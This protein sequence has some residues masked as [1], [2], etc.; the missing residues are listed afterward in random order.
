M[1]II[2]VSGVPGTGKT[3]LA[4][5]L[6]DYLE[7]PAINLSEYAINSMLVVGYDS[8]IQ[9][10]IV[11]EEK[12]RQ[13]ILELYLSRGPMIIDSHYVEILPRE[14]LEIVFVLRRAPDELIDV[15]LSRGW[16]GRKIA[17]NVEAELLSICT[18]NAVEELGDDLV[19][20]IDVTGRSVDDV[21]REAI[22]I[23]FGSK[24]AYYGHRI[25][26]LSTLS[27]DRIES[28]LRYIEMNR[29]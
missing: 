26:W 19:I 24:S 28:V 6:S 8:S 13:S 2:G 14:I 12:L 27:S 23:L 22:D 1:K 5:A 20:E 11:D 25:D 4:R 29:E 17:E 21:A 9:S 7:I 15:L 10:Y 16:S 18:I 3:L